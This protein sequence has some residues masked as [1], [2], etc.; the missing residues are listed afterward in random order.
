M[1]AGA[2]YHS[3]RVMYVVTT[4]PKCALWK[5]VKVAIYF[6]HQAEGLAIGVQDLGK[7]FNYLYT[8]HAL[9]LFMDVIMH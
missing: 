1:E 5:V 9:P 3:I 7:D 4:E 6:S 8:S 2:L